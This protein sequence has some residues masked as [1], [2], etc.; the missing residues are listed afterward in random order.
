MATPDC[1]KGGNP[2]GG[3]ALGTT[4]MSPLGYWLPA[5][6]ATGAYSHPRRILQDSGVIGYCQASISTSN[7]S[8]TTMQKELEKLLNRISKLAWLSQAQSKPTIAL[9]QPKESVKATGLFKACDV[10]LSPVIAWRLW[11]NQWKS[12]NATYAPIAHSITHP[13]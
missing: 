5:T 11:G 3:K 9:T 10:G 1:S 2:G 6:T 12:G 4:G 8:T 7:S 13:D